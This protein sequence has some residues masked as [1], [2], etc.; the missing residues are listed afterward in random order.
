MNE[1]S[2][3]YDILCQELFKALPKKQVK[4]VF[5]QPMC[6]IDPSFLGFIDIYYYL[7]KMIPKHWAIIDL[8][9][10]YNPQSWYFR[11]HKQYIAVDDGKIKRF[12]PKNCVI[13]NMPIHKFI[14]DVLDGLISKVIN[15]K[16][17]FAICSYVN[18][19]LL[20]R[21]NFINLFM[22]YPDGGFEP[23]F[24]KKALKIKDKAHIVLQY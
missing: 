17:T 7:S 8:G 4:E 10:A 23:V 2:Q 3:I 9:C 1:Q 19:D 24:L 18:N 13:Y 14:D 22:Y 15:I 11:N 21:Q 6:D 12:R 20:I 16:Q 5:N